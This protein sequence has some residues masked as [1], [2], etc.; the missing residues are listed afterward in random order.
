MAYLSLPP[1]DQARL[2]PMI[3]GFNPTDMYAVDHIQRVLEMFPGVFSGVGEFTI[4]KEFVS[5]KITGEI[6]SLTNPALSHVYLDL[7]WDETAKYVTST[8][9]TVERSAAMINRFHE[10][11]LFGSDVVAPASVDA[12]VDV[13]EI[14]APLWE[15]L[16]PEVRQLVLVGN[17]KRIFDRAR[18]RVRAWEKGNVKKRSEP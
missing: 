18:E 15:K 17:Y 7:S 16:T 9:Q 6:A 14:Y 8:P 5:S 10:R 4:H 1:E 2:E 3:T 12:M 13:F 11:F